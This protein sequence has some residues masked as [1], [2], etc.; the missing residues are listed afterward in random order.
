VHCG[1]RGLFSKADLRALSLILAIVVSLGSA[2]STAGFVIISGPSHAELTINI[3]QPLQTLDRVSDM[4]LA[5][6][7]TVLPEFVL[8]DFG[9]TAVKKAVRLVDLKVAP[10]TPPPKRSV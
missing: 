3:C 9:S 10:D 1:M 7:A 4:P 6:P 5:R 2:P 8:W